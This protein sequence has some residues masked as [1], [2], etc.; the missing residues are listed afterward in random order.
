MIQKK[1]IVL[2]SNLKSTNKLLLFFALIKKKNTLD[3]IDCE[4]KSLS[5]FISFL[6][7]SHGQSEINWVYKKKNL[8]TNVFKIAPFLWL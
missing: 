1:N 4:V 8:F 5:F 3:H 6:K 2:S 7:F